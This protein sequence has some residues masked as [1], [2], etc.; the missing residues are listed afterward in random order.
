MI[1]SGYDDG[2]F[3]IGDSRSLQVC[4]LLEHLFFWY[5]SMGEFTHTIEVVLLTMV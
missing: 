3:R 5:G 2:T 1:A 4:L